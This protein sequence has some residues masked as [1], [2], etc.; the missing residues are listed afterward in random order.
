MDFVSIAN[1][2]SVF[3]LGFF[4]FY[5]FSTNGN[6]L[7]CL[8]LGASI[9]FQSLELLNSLFYRFFD[10]WINFPSVF[11]S[12]EVTFFLWGPFF[13]L[14]ILSIT[15]LTFKID[16]AKLLHC[17]P[18]LIH[19]LFLIIV[20]H[21]KPSEYKIEALQNNS[22]IVPYIDSIIHILK[23]ASTLLYII[24]AWY[25]YTSYKKEIL[26]SNPAEIHKILWIKNVFAFFTVIALI[27]IIHYFQIETLVYN[28]I[29]YS[30]TIPIWMLLSFALL[31][32]SL[33]NPD[34]ILFIPIKEKEIMKA[35]ISEPE[36]EILSEKIIRLMEEEKIYLQHE[37]KLED[38]AQQL[39]ITTKKVSRIINLRFGVNFSDFINSYRIELAKQLLSD[40]NFN[41]DTMLGIAY[42]VGFNSK[43]TFNRLFLKHTSYTPKEYKKQY[44][45]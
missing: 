28:T 1:I 37:L 9:F 14:Y 40:P 7:S 27:Q 31:F 6:K 30:I 35:E 17:I 45:G 32:Y 23:N 21:S 2:V 19:T 18:A 43:S 41:K 39:S 22:A 10:Y 3:F 34:F 16:R 38:I 20:F 29:I 44:S 26:K 42:E 15:E 12:T 13:Y 25:K 36:L 5:L 4:A 11:Y 8:L 33:K 24:L